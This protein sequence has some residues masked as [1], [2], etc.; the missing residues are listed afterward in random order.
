M[1]NSNLAQ[2][3]LN[4]FHTG[5][6]AA[7]RKLTQKLLKTSPSL[8][9]GHLLL[10]LIERA[11]GR[12]KQAKAA[13][14]RA[15]KID[16]KHPDAIFNLASHHL[17]NGEYQDAAK[18]YRIATQLLP[19]DPKPLIGLAQALQLSDR[20]LGLVGQKPTNLE[21][22]LTSYEK[23][24]LLVPEDA[25]IP[26]KI[27]SL[28][29]QNEDYERAIEWQKRV[30]SLKN[31]STDS[32]VKLATLHLVS[33]DKLQSL[34][35]CKKARKTGGTP[36]LMELAFRL[37][38]WEF[39]ESDIRKIDQ[40]AHDTRA[41]HSQQ[42]NM[43]FLLGA[44]FDKKDEYSKAISHLDRANSGKRQEI[45][46][47][48]NAA[49]TRFDRLKK[50]FTSDL[51]L[52][53]SAEISPRPIF[54]IG[55]PRSGTTL[56]EQILASHSKVFGAG[57]TTDLDVV[58]NYLSATR[59]KG[60]F[61]EVLKDLSKDDADRARSIYGDALSKYDS[62]ATH[63]TNKSIS[64]FMYA[65]LIAQLFP[66]S[67]IIHCRRNPYAT[68]FSCYRE[69]FA[70]GLEYTYSLE[71]FAHH[72]R[73]YLDIMEHWKTVLPEGRILE[74]DYEQLVSSP[75][76][77]IQALAKHCCLQWEDGLLNFHENSRAVKT[78]SIMQVRQPIYKKSLLHWENYKDAIVPKLGDL[79][80]PD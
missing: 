2:E 73:L 64:N 43:S 5:K 22:A 17:E 4:L 47:D 30:V 40:W 45:E 37:G 3:A 44:I 34:E 71:D 62:T 29:N 72:Y 51:V 69:N 14:R 61:P 68:C 54:I 52:P 33:G 77:S 1:R 59:S 18:Y 15:I 48:H 6:L 16:P 26:E 21:E 27:V 13:L 76:D 70:E 80:H 31:E 57:E 42:V 79:A 74:L 66:E 50:V 75:E 41:S 25:A 39:T 38:A 20:A 36:G 8:V 35:V 28:L 23:A 7:A 67:C 58:I 55:M 53:V 10:A 24:T 19:N 65:G 11:D 9:D 32:L 56:V 46:Y 60:S 12:A 78:A 63:V 49:K